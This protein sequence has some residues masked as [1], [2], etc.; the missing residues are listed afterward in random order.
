[1]LEWDGQ[2]FDPASFFIAQDDYQTKDILQ[3][4]RLGIP[5]G[6]DGHLPYRFIDGNFVQFVT[7]KPREYC[8]VR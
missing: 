6:R 3:T 8:Y 2:A 4:I 7:K 5:E 1:M